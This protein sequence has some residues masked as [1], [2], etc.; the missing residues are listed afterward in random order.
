MITSA[1]ITDNYFDN[2]NVS[3]ETLNV[4]TSNSNNDIYYLFNFIRNAARVEDTA[5]PIQKSFISPLTFY[6]FTN[7]KKGTLKFVS[8][9]EIKGT[10][11]VNWE[12]Q[13]CVFIDPRNVEQLINFQE[14]VSIAQFNDYVIELIKENLI[15]DKLFF[16]P[17]TDSVLNATEIEQY[18][19]LLLEIRSHGGQVFVATNNIVV[20]QLLSEEEESSWYVLNEQNSKATLNR[21]CHG[22]TPY[23]ED[24]KEYIAYSVID[25]ENY[26]D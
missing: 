24:Q 16:F 9:K 12:A 10:D 7:D 25:E 4:F 20:S 13:E 21:V 22:C 3:F 17:F 18:V 6:A 1:F 2:V 15:K 5:F 19:A 23:F 26:N 8:T 11:L 14:N